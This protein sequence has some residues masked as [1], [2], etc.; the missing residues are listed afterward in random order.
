MSCIQPEV[1]LER[2]AQAALVDGAGH[3]G[4]GGGL[5]GDGEPADAVVVHQHVGRLEER[6]RLEVLAAAVLVGPPLAVL[7]GVVEVEH[8][9]HGIDPQRVGVELVDPEAGVREQ[10]V[11][12]ALPAEVEDVGAPVGV[13]AAQRVGVLVERG[14][15]EAAE[16]PLVLGEVGRHP[17]EDHADAGLVEGVDEVLEVVGRRPSG[18]RG[19]STR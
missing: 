17:V 6:H 4:P 16:R 9:G 14:A 15:V 5:L 11:A 19:R 18:R 8:R 12:D 7:A 1:P 10:E 2:E 13:L 3:A